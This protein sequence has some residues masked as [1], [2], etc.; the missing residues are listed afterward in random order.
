MKTRADAVQAIRHLLTQLENNPNSWENP[1]LDRYLDSLAAWLEAS[2]KKA[3]R[4]PSWDLI[5]E[6]LEA[7]KIYE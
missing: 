4:T 3:D 5:I 2:G 1:T 7:A 6:M